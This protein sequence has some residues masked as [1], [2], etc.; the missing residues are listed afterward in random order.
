[1]SDELGPGGRPAVTTSTAR[2]EGGGRAASGDAPAPVRQWPILLIIAGVVAGLVTTASGAFRAGAIVV[3]AALLLGGAL[4]WGMASV[5][6]LAVRSR[7][8]DVITYGILGVAIILLALMAQPDP[9]IRIPFLE[10]IIHFS[11]R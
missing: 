4:R 5:G 7:F 9:L 6:M 8:T 10:D 2:P 11:V 3:G 1:M